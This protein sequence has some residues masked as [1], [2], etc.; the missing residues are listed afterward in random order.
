MRPAEVLLASR[1]AA[2]ELAGALLLGK[3]ARKT[4]DDYLRKQLTWH[5]YEEA[6]HAC[7][8][9]KVL[10]DKNLPLMEVHG[11]NEYF[12]YASQLADDIEFLA[13]AHVY[14]LRSVFHLKQ[15]AKLGTLDAAFKKAMLRI[16]G[17]EDK[18]LDWIAVYLKQRQEEGNA[19]IAAYVSK[20]GEVENAT[21]LKFVK[22]TLTSSDDAYL[23]DLGKLIEDNLSSYA[24]EWKRLL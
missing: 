15:H 12:G 18:H 23:R 24:F 4:S 5:C 14:E 9:T 2:A 8:W 3:Y 20:W 13:W 6:G 7:L 19:N 16:I 1:Y 10:Q 17:E 22:G 11:K 21:Y